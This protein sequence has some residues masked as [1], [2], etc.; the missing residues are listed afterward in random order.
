MELT[1]EQEKKILQ[2]IHNTL[3]KVEVAENINQYV[4][5]DV[6]E[7]INNFIKQLDKIRN[8]TTRT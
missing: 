8:D 2:Y 3:H 7:F 1:E 4:I 5:E 6:V